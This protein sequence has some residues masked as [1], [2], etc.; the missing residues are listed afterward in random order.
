[1]PTSDVVNEDSHY[2][3]FKLPRL[4][5]PLT[6]APAVR[7]RRDIGEI[8]KAGGKIT[9]LVDKRVTLNIPPG[10]LK[11]DCTYS[12]QVSSILS[13]KLSQLILCI[14]PCFPHRSSPLVSIMLKYY[15][16]KIGLLC[17]NS[18]RAVL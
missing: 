13:T 5:V 10:G 6:F 18:H 17:L 11:I 12:I 9:S 14:H 16:T 3:E 15:V 8:G 7:I 1:M 2:L 4:T